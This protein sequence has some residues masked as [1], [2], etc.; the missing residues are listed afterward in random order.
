MMRGTAGVSRS[1]L[2]QVGGRRL[3]DAGVDS[4]DRTDGMDGMDGMDA[5]RSLLGVAYLRLN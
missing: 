5:G 1:R 3:S 4:M 2:L